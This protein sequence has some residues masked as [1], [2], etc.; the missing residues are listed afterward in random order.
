MVFNLFC[1]APLQ[2]QRH[3]IWKTPYQSTALSEGWLL[4]KIIKLQSIN[5]LFFTCTIH[6]YQ[7]T[8]EQRM[9]AWHDTTQHIRRA[10]KLHTS[11]SLSVIVS[12]QTWCPVALWCAPELSPVSVGDPADMT[13]CCGDARPNLGESASGSCPWLI[14]DVCSFSTP[15]CMTRCR[16]ESEVRYLNLVAQKVAA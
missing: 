2:F 14:I 11:Q 7:S 10:Q 9:R 16:R 12:R 8:T 15:T 3:V 5:F 4:R 13:T 1:T 6:V